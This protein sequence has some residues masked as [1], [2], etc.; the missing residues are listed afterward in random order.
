MRQQE[1]VAFTE[2]R[3]GSAQWHRCHDILAPKSLR[4]HSTN[5]QHF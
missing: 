2:G 1:E 5:A 4:V 3:G